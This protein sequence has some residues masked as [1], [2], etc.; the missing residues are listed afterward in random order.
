MK[1]LCFPLKS[2]VLTKARTHLNWLMTLG[3]LAFAPAASHADP[4]SEIASFSSLSKPDYAKIEKG[5]IVSA[6]SPGMTYARGLGI[7]SVFAVEAPFEK[8]VESLKEWNGAGHPDLKVYLH[9]DIASPSNPASFSK[10]AAAPGNGAV[11]SLAAATFKLNPE[12]PDLQ[13][14]SS[15]AALAPKSADGPS[16]LPPAA[17]G[18]W[19]ALLDKRARAFASGGA[20]AQPAYV[21]GG[22]KIAPA[23]ELAALLR[24]QPRLHNQFKA[25]IA[26]AGAG[27]RPSRP[28]LYWEMVDGDGEAILNLGSTTET[29]SAGSAQC[30]DIQYYASGNYYAYITLYQLWPMPGGKASTLV[31]RADLVSSA[32]LGALHGIERNAAGS[33]F[34]KEVER[35]IAHFQKDTAH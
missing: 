14:S 20:P 5:G 33:A 7:E 30:V 28:S 26:A 3:L 6:R 23:E 27:G 10:L 35:L 22:Q 19:S 11:R 9:G 16:P 34:A 2:R 12:T 29:I 8:T 31:W 18:F 1:K 21:V 15:E 32:S 4:A 17:A 24:A 13:M 25:A